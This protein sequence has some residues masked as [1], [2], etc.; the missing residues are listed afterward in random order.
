[1]VF[2]VV[3]SVI[4][5]A[6]G[7]LA[8]G[9]TKMLIWS[10]LGVLFNLMMYMLSRSMPIESAK[11]RKCIYFSLFGMFLIV[12]LNVGDA[13]F[14]YLQEDSPYKEVV[15]TYQGFAR[16]I[17]VIALVAIAIAE[18]FFM[19]T[20]VVF[21]GVLALFVNGARTDLVC[22]LVATVF[23]SFTRFGILKALSM[24]A[25]FVLSI[26][27]ALYIF[28]S[29]IYEKFVG[30]NRVLELFDLKSSTSAQER[31][32]LN[33]FAVRT[34]SKNPI[35]GDYASYLNIPGISGTSGVGS[36]AHNILSAWVNL[37]I[38]GFIGYIYIA[39]LI[40]FTVAKNWKRVREGG[41]EW[42]LVVAFSSFSIVAMA[43]GQD[44]TYLVFGF[45]V[46]FCARSIS[47]RNYRLS[48]VLSATT[49]R[50]VF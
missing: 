12:V 45:A 16:S 1:M 26:M 30:K 49:R 2:S 3:V 21:I 18:G 46:G 32:Y 35:F 50:S 29:E 38:F 5:F 9:N 24:S 19:F 37:G 10:L 6:D 42:N 15:A 4:N 23:L 7:R 22:F 43:S 31:Y 39:I 27:L 40:G 44:Y 47:N 14:F 48:G 33:E 25:G 8:L 34:I 17:A 13:G 20:M 41:A 11:F 28:P 36:Y